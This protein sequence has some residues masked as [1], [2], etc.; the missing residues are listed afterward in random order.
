MSGEQAGQP[1]YK[2]IGNHPTQAED[3][4]EPPVVA[5]GTEAGSSAK[6]VYGAQGEMASIAGKTSS[7]AHGPKRVAGV[8]SSLSGKA[9]PSFGKP[10]N[11]NAGGGFV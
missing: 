2:A 8:Q 1:P 5:N 7:N 6:P 11:K 3:P 9:N 10:A 4:I